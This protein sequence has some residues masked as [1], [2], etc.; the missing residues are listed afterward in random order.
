[1]LPLP[2]ARIIMANLF[3][4]LIQALRCPDAELCNPM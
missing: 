4:V 1:M 2:E 3:E